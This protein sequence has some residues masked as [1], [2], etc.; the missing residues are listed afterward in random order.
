VTEATIRP[1]AD[2]AAG[3][4]RRLI[5]S[6]DRGVDGPAVVVVAGIHGNE[7]AGCEAAQAVLAHLERGRVPLRGRFCALAGN[8][9][10]L[11]QRQRYET[12]DLNRGWSAAS[13]ARA[14]QAPRD[15]EDLEQAE[16][17]DAIAAELERDGRRGVVLDLHS[18][19]APG[20]PFAVLADTLRNRPIAF[21][22][23][24]PVILGLEERLDGTLIEFLVERGHVAVA[25]EG[26]Q[27]DAPE[28]ARRLEAALWLALEAA[29]SLDAADVPGRATQLDI[30]RQASSGLPDVVEVLY[31]H[32]VEP[33]DG[34]RMDPGFVNF[35]V[36]TKDQRLA[37]DARGE[38]RSP[39]DGRLLLPLYQ[40]KGDDGFFIGRRVKRFW[41][42]LSA[43]VRGLRLDRLAPLLPGVSRDPGH[44]DHLLAD[45]RVARWFTVEVFHLL[46][47]RRQRP[48]GGR[49]QF[50][51]RRPDHLPPVRLDAG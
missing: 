18:T 30:L 45:P 43:V 21:A 39:A 14:K 44:P 19:S 3:T 6:W 12:R 51:R 9:R 41:L 27:H 16:L 26:G 33:A 37:Q 4:Y 34:F 20:P 17:V 5:G 31:R 50:S 7:P 28:T 1:T 23:G 8:L 48:L 35:D 15:D 38:V 10:S 22:L 46:G 36:V 25:V 11:R 40:A 32:G 29:G 47:Y 42:H 13:I 24:V 49:L 2:D